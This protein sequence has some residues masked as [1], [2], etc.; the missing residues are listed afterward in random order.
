MAAVKD[1]NDLRDYEL[2]KVL[3]R[4]LMGKVQL[5]KDRRDNHYV[6]IKS[7]AKASVSSEKEVS[8]LWEERNILARM[9]SCPF[10]VHME[11]AFQTPTH[12]IF[13]LEYHPGGD[14]AGILAR[15]GT[16]SEPA[17][18]FYAAE[19][20]LALRALHDMHVV[21]RDLKPENVL[22]GRDGH[23]VLTDFGLSRRTLTDPLLTVCGTADY[24]APEVLEAAQGY[25]RAVDLWSLGV[26]V[27]EMVVGVPPYWDEHPAE[28]YRKIKE[29]ASLR[30]PRHVSEPVRD[31]CRS[32]LK[33]TPRERLGYASMDDLE[34][35]PAFTSIDWM[36]IKAKQAK[37]PFLPV[38]ANDVDVQYFDPQFTTMP[39]MF[40]PAFS[41]PD[42]V[43]AFYG[44]TFR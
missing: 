43:K 19:L 44:F 32:L 31:L 41:S 37:P 13:V 8:Q 20:A 5:A 22:I 12:L 9:T 14:L 25:D 6:A 2:I 23:L 24:L 7:I 1:T 26:M 4:G 29:A 10:L 21:Y 18:L 28:M 38:I 15:H 3:G 35:H 39:P 33:R 40:T 11:A 17:A 36:L 27:Y 16:V 42:N 30:F 34:R